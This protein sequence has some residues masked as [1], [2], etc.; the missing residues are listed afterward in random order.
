MYRSK[1][2]DKGQNMS[3]TVSESIHLFF[4]LLRKS[5]IKHLLL[6]GIV[7]AKTENIP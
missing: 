7:D 3:S 6:L 2:I 1:G 5:F 4:H